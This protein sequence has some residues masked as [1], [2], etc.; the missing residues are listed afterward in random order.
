MISV[1]S[2]SLTLSR[3]EFETEWM[4]AIGG[5]A[6]LTADEIT[7]LMQWDLNGNLPT[8]ELLNYEANMAVYDID[9]VTALQTGDL[10]MGSILAP[11][12]ADKAISMWSHGALM[13]FAEG[14]HTPHSGDTTEEWVA[15][16]MEF[17][18]L[19]MSSS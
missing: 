18:S 13:H 17:L 4:M 2:Q 9:V 7:E 15:R 12:I 19:S 10:D 5:S 16:T 14:T 1:L 11:D 3:E 6:N 8:A